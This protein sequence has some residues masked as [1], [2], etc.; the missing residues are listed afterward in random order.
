M[1]TTVLR[2]IRL[3]ETETE[4]E[5]KSID[6]LERE[7]NGARPPASPDLAYKWTGLMEGIENLDTDARMQAR[8][9]VRASFSRIVIWHSGE[10]PDDQKDGSGRVIEMELTARGGGSTRIRVGAASGRIEGD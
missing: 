10:A 5:K 2:S 1:L 7:L 4:T 3:L 9:M 8:E 6:G